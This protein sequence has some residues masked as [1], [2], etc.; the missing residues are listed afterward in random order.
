MGSGWK[1]GR[2]TSPI[3]GD[4]MAKNE[5]NNFDGTR[6]R[7]SA[8]VEHP[9]GDKTAAENDVTVGCSVRIP[10]DEG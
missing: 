9:D 2:F 1:V 7:G 6:G 5:D 10:S 3:T 8:T 4:S